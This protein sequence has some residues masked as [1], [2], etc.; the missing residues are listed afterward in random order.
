MHELLITQMSYLIRMSD[1]EKE[2]IRQRFEIKTYQKGEYFLRE[3]QVCREAG[4]IVEGM[5]RYVLTKD[6]GEELTVDF[7]KEMEY[8]CNYASFLDK[9]PSESAIQCIEPTTIIVISYDDLQELYEHFTEG[10]K[11]GRLI[12][13]FLYVQAIKK[14]QSLYT[15][16]PERRYLQFLDVYSNLV[17]RLPQYYISS[18]VGVQPPSL[19]RIRKRLAK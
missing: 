12:C 6:N 19:S 15:G 18:Y 7:N 16:D 17:P 13:E 14:V 8:T 11:F 1:E 4:F 3:G 2:W 5:V 9:S 10:Q